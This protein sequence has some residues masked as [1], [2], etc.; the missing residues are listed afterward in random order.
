MMKQLTISGVHLEVNADLRKYVAKKIGNLDRYVPRKARQSVRTE[1]RLKDA[2]AKDKLE[3]VCEIVMHVPHST[4]NI[5][6][7]AVNIYAAVDIAEA[8]L[9]AQ[10][11]KYKETHAGPRLHRRLMARFAGRAG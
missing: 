5:E 9:L 4:L 1:I 11:H 10:L 7:K 6:T 3:W 2:K 8:T